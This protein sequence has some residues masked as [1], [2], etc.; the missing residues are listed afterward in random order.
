MRSSQKAGAAN[1][2]LGQHA[3]CWKA[4]TPKR[5]TEAEEERARDKH[6]SQRQEEDQVGITVGGISHDRERELDQ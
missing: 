5:S 3:G 6:Q 2:V 4:A 1:E